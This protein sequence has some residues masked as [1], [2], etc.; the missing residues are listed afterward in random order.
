MSS[1]Y[2]GLSKTHFTRTCYDSSR[3]N[4]PVTSSQDS[5]DIVE[6]MSDF[7]FFVDKAN[8]SYQSLLNEP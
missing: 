5:R 8:S 4:V 1:T 7:L 2:D 6:L 3:I